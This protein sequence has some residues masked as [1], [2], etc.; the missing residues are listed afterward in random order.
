M[1]AVANGALDAG[2]A[3]DGLERLGDFF[4]F[5]QLAHAHGIDLGNGHAERQLVLFETDD[6]QFERKSCNFLF[7]DGLDEAN[8]MGGVNDILA[9]LEARTLRGLFSCHIGYSC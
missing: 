4:G 7:L 6:E 2:A 3:G 8:T 9:G 5:G 1:G